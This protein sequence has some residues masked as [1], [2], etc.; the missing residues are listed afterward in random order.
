MKSLIT[1]LFISLGSLMMSAQTT[2][3]TN[4]MEYVIGDVKQA[5]I[6]DKISTVAQVLNLL[7]GFETLKVNGIR[8]PIFAKG[9]EPDEQAL[10]YFYQQAVEAGFDVFANPVHWSGGQRV[11]NGVFE[12]FDENFG[13]PVK[14][15]PEKTQALIDR[16]LEI[17][18]LYP[19]LTWINPFN[20]DGSPG[21]AW[22]ADQMNTIYKTLSEKLV[23]AELIGACPWGIPAGIKVLKNT[24]VEN[25]ITV[26]TTHNLGFNHSS[27][28]EFINL[29]HAANLPAWDS[30]VNHNVRTDLDPTGTTR[31]EA[32]I[33]YGVDGMVLY[34]SW[35]AINLNTGE[36][37]SSGQEWMSHYLKP[38]SID[39][40]LEN[41]TSLFDVYSGTSSFTIR[42]LDPFVKSEISVVNLNGKVI[43][44]LISSGTQDIEIDAL[45]AGVYVVILNANNQLQREKIL[46]F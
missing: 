30:E 37:N 43:R 1:I 18:L 11:A 19:D 10:I 25:Y 16:I 36:V 5:F 4:D 15:N 39:D 13:G 17:D 26:S 33:A 35:S 8:I 31:L 2:I 22:S 42:L 24:D 14:D 32:A 40:A 28:T 3:Y 44:Q 34:D 6:K 46:V 38:A 21:G 20:E 29:S 41:K 45:Q 23:N 7:K 9:Y 12:D 27:W